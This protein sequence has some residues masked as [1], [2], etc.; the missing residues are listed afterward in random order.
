VVTTVTPNPDGLLNLTVTPK[1]D[2]ATPAQ[3]SVCFT[4]GGRSFFSLDSNPPAA[5][6]TRAIEFEVQRTNGLLRRTVVLPNGN[7]RLAL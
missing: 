3:I 7:A 5:P 1:Y 2:G 4:P 6:L